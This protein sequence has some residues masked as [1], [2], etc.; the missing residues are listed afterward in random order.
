MHSSTSTPTAPQVRFGIGTAVI[1]LALN[2]RPVMAGVGPLLDQIERSAGLNH[3]EAGLLTTLPVAAMGACALFGWRLHAAFG[4]RRGTALGMALVALACLL[5]LAWPSRWGLLLTAALAGM[6]VA[7]VQV[8]LPAFLKRSHGAAAG[9][10]LGLYTTAIMGGAACAAATAAN[11]ADRFGL[12]AALGVWALPAVIALALWLGVTRS[13]GPRAAAAPMRQPP[14]WWRRRRAWE[15]LVFFGIGTGAYTLVLAWLP[16]YYTGL[17]WQ[18]ADAG[19]LLGGLTVT[20]VAAGLAVSAL[21]GRRRD[22]RV[23]LLAALGLLSAG[24]VCLVAAPLALA[25]PAA[26][27]LGMGIGALFPLTLILTVE[28]V[29]DPAA[30]GA[31]A[32]FVQGGGYLVASLMPLLAGILRDTLSNL[33]HAWLVMLG[34][35]LVLAALALR[36]SPGSYAGV[37][38]PFLEE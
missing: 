38:K 4:E 28:H 2:L 32:A 30:A 7:C 6:G 19:Y 24:L 36:F 22:L 27:L 37:S 21:A 1:C 13:A 33:A 11:A 5:R 9:T 10:M 15:L 16:A 8:L 12:G 14:A 25:L 26:G 34:G 31:L 3:A 18:R 23:A 20:E 17:G 29:D 35:C